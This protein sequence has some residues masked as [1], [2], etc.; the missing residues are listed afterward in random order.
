MLEGIF[1][2]DNYIPFLKLK[3]SEISAIRDLDSSLKTN[4]LPF[5]DFPRKKPKKSRKEDAPTPKTKSELFSNDLFKLRR[6]FEINLNFL[7]KFY[8]DNFD[9]EDFVEHDGKYSYYSILENFGPFG[10]IPVVGL[11]RSEEHLKSVLYALKENIIS[12][13]RIAIRLCK[14]DF[15]SYSICRNELIAL[16]DE[17]YFSFN[18]IDLIFDCR[19]CKE[20]SNE[21]FTEQILKFI[22][23][24]SKESYSFHRFIISGSS[25]PPSIT[26][27]ITTR[28]E[29]HISREEILIYN[30]IHSSMSKEN[31]EKTNIFI[32]DYGCVS[33]EYS[34]VELFEEDMDNITTAK[35]I[36]PYN[37]NLYL[38]RGG[39]MKSDREQINKLA[40]TIVTQT[41]IYRG[42]S[43][44]MGDRYLY[45]KSNGVGKL[46]TAST[47]V[48]PLV[49]LHLTYMLNK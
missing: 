20:D 47:I 12:D 35:I 7:S 2:M 30:K 44:S 17:I 8:L 48:A 29:K 31:R 36:Y 4:L 40:K 33:P 9:L 38:V 14:N 3:G 27:L 46:A 10:M 32:A 16:L 5:F 24:L 28:S 18:E 49:N 6:K 25:I 45:D 11:D 15:E 37:D 43:F 34:D 23:G 22:Q 42:S 26:E 19:I 21:K 1:S 41:H 39:R 13:S